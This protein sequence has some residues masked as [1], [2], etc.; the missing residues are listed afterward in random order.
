MATVIEI[1]CSGKY[2]AYMPSKEFSDAL[3]EEIQRHLMAYGMR[4]VSVSLKSTP[5]EPK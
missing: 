2:D 4:D 1:H 3:C 5:G